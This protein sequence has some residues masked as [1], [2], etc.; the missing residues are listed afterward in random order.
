LLEASARAVVMRAED[1]WLPRRGAKRVAQVTGMNASASH[2]INVC[3]TEIRRGG[4]KSAKRR[5]DF[6]RATASGASAAQAEL[7]ANNR[8]NM[9]TAHDLRGCPDRRPNLGPNELEVRA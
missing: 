4:R 8:D 6:E 7:D 5:R 1:T 3:G 9:L 2:S